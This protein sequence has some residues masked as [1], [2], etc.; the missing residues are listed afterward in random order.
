MIPR[1]GDEDCIY[2]FS[3]SIPREGYIYILY[4]DESFTT[5]Y[6]RFLVRSLFHLVICLVLPWLTDLFKY[7]AYW[8]H[9]CRASDNW[10]GLARR[11]VLHRIKEMHSYA[12]ESWRRNATG[13]LTGI[14]LVSCTWV[15]GRGGVGDGETAVRDEGLDGV[16][17]ECLHRETL[18]LSS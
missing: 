7:C 9:R 10:L 1:L 17:L 15:C 18:K 4:D 16:W 8:Y 5:L 14:L 3:K 2:S 13:M 12:D 6:S 11:W